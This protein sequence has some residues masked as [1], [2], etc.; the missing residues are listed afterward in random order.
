MGAHGRGGYT[1]GYGDGRGAVIKV[2]GGGWKTVIPSNGSCQ[3]HVGLGEDLRG[4]V[5]AVE[6]CCAISGGRVTIGAGAAAGAVG[7]T[8]AVSGE[9]DCDCTLLD[10]PV[11][12]VGSKV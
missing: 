9:D 11:S 3:P 1:K 7:A 8:A 12:A 4:N 5:Q 2:V 6:E 10:I